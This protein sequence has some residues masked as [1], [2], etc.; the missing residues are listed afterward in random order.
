MTAGNSLTATA[1]G[2]VPLLPTQGTGLTRVLHNVPLMVGLTVLACVALMALLAPWLFPGDPRQMI[3]TPMLP[4]FEDGAFLLGTG[5]LGTDL[6]AG[7]A[8]GARASLFIGLSAA[9]VGLVIGTLVGAVG[10]YLGGVVE[11]ATVRVTEVFQTI[12]SFLL[13]IVLVTIWSP[14]LPIIAIAIGVSSWPMIARLVRAEFRS[15]R[16]ADFVLAAKALGYGRLRI[17]FLEMLPSALPPVIVATS[18]LAANAILTEAGLSFLGLGDPD[19]ISWGSMIGDGRS[20]L[21]TAWSVAAIPGAATTILVAA[22]NLIGD[23]LNDAL[24]PRK[25]Q[26]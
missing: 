3:G 23:G 17:I 1:P 11:D 2:D 21:R 14:S 15:L 9:L 7:L 5:S 22:M 26:S 4:P 13:V 6:A 25:N 8:H 18:F 19:M 16:E 20:L 10:G 24:N 12:P